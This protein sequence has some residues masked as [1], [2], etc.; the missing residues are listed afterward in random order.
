MALSFLHWNA[1][2]IVRTFLIRDSHFVQ[3]ASIRVIRVTK[4]PD[5]ITIGRGK[6]ELK[7]VPGFLGEPP[8]K[9]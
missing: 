6:H 2:S 1:N 3:F 8:V 7:N 4:N 9:D 5:H